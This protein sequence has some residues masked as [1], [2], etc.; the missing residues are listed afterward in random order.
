MS[1]SG[2][3]RSAFRFAAVLL[4]CTAVALTGC[5]GHQQSAVDPSGPQAGKIAT[6]LWF[7]IWLLTA[8]FVIVMALTV[9]TLMRR[10]R[11]IEQEPLEAMHRPSD[12]TEKRLTRLVTAATYELQRSNA[13]YALCT[14]CIG[15]G[16]GIAMVIERV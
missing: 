3:R 9:W 5:A 13:R 14:M 10:H 2:A 15:V 16:Q 7:F 6:L 11:G 1:D 4:A 12:E 8:I